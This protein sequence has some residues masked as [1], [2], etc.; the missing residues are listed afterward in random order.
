MLRFLTS[1]IFS[2]AFFS[3]DAI[4]LARVVDSSELF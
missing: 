2:T 4:E 1:V 3:V